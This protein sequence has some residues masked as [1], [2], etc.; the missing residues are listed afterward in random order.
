VSD[1]EKMEDLKPYEP[2]IEGSALFL[3]GVVLP[4]VMFFPWRMETH[5]GSQ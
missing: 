4:V 1:S 2:R 3:L 5:H